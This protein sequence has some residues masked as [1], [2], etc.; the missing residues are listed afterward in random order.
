MSELEPVALHRARDAF[1]RKWADMSSP[2]PTE[3][4]EAGDGPIGYAIR[5]YLEAAPAN[6][7]LEAARAEEWR[8]RREAEA[9]RDTMSA[10]AAT[11]KAERDAA[12]ALLKEAGPV[13]DKLRTALEPLSNR[14]FND[15]GDISVNY[16][17]NFTSEHCISAY[18]AD[19]AARSLMSK[20]GEHNGE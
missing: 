18:F 2:F 6:A 20:I 19:R 17:V 7:E 4:P 8:K 15:N 10:V 3:E 12:E 16:P 1:N 5:A 13:I 9:S 14:V 11:F